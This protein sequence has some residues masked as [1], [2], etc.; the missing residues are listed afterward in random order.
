MSC[1]ADA[2]L[3]AISASLSNAHRRLGR[4]LVCYFHDWLTLSA[5]RQPIIGC[6]IVRLVPS[7]YDYDPDQDS[8]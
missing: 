5:A 7:G 6:N 4:N 8:T 2:V 3:D 1:D